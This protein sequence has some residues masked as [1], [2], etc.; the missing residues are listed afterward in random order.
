M[1]SQPKKSQQFTL[2]LD[3]VFNVPNILKILGVVVISYAVVWLNSNFVSQ[4]EYKKEYKHLEDRVAVVENRSSSTDK[5]LT[6][7]VSQ[8]D[9]LTNE[10]K[11]LNDRLSIVITPNGTLIYNDKFISMSQ[12]IESM[13]RDITWIKDSIS[14]DKKN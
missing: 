6:T 5:Q 7:Y 10:I 2:D 9:N 14:H 4:E 12:D 11:K 8:Y 3:K 1:I 13:K